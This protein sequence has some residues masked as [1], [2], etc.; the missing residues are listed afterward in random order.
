MHIVRGPGA[1]CR[2][3]YWP[4]WKKGRSVSHW[5]S[6]TMIHFYCWFGT[7]IS[8]NHLCTQLLQCSKGKK[9]KER[10][11]E[12]WSWGCSGSVNGIRM[13]CSCYNIVTHTRGGNR[14][15]MHHRSASLSNY[16][17]AFSWHNFSKRVFLLLLLLRK[18][19]FSCRGSPPSDTQHQLYCGEIWPDFKFA[20]KKA[21]WTCI[22]KIVI[23]EV[24]EHILMFWQLG[25]YF[26][27][28]PPS[29]F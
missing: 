29:Y 8:L 15:L 13:P 12:K 21:F 3:D 20:H 10:R 16:C 27:I 22:V 2:S 14:L 24:R 11:Q 9:K 25:I 6:R 26:L 17:T 4:R 5:A 23:F 19:V 7:E 28:A 18:D 1:G